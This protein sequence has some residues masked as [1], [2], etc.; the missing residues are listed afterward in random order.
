MLQ[1][2]KKAFKILSVK[3]KKMIVLLN[4][5][6]I[7]GALME[8]LGISLILP[9]ITAIIDENN[10]QKTWYAG[11]ICNLFSIQDKKIY[12][13]ILL[14]LLIAVFIVKN[15]YLLFEIYTQ[16]TFISRCRYQMQKNLM[17]C[18]MKKPYA[19]YLHANSGEIMRIMHNDTY[20][21]FN[22]LTTLIQIYTEGFVCVI[23]GAT[24][25]VLS[26]V[27]AA[28]LIV[29]LALEMLLIAL[30]VK[31][32][33]KE[34]GREFRK[35]S[36]ISYNWMLQAVNGIK[37]IKVA[38][39]ENYFCDNYAKSAGKVVNIERKNLTLGDVPRL[40]IEALT[41][42]SVLLMVLIMVINGASLESIVPQLSAFVVAAIRLLPGANRISAAINR[43]PF[44]EGG[45]DNVL[46]TLYEE[47]G[48]KNI[49]RISDMPFQA[50]FEKNDNN[51]KLRKELKV[52]NIT[53]CYPG[54]D[55][56][57]L[58]NADMSIYPGQS[59]GIIGQSG[60][61]KTTVMDIML[62]LLKPDKGE[63]IADGRNIEED[64]H[65]W[66]RNVSYIPQQIFL[67]DD[68]IIR[69][70]AFGENEEDID[71]TLVWKALEEA[72]LKDFVKSLPEGLNT[73]VGEQGIRLSGGQK[74]RIGI[75]RALYHDP[76]IIF[77][78]EA[79]SALDNDTENAIM[80]SINHL[81]G[82]KTLVIIAHRLTTIQNCDVVYKVE[83]GKIIKEGRVYQ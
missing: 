8:S 57:V 14:L 34:G 20:Q 81:K 33:L 38:N 76:D 44:Y 56:A 74:Q 18:F 28:E 16:N 66:L 47:G 63:I 51:M 27:I 54:S 82:K 36:A 3:Q 62:G 65:A 29:T 31:P 1:A 41:V 72:Q 22:L 32:I 69:N 24:I 50:S 75:A 59:A 12:I 71:Q 61:G 73:V 25:F 23:L 37:S 9:L 45:L 78:D 55:T 79:T 70:V 60:A 80:E 15:V 5:M 19:Y 52:R 77:F 58:L 10:W 40:L 68:S 42:A 7:L 67:I 2:T 4:V 53:F 49:Q 43:I 30:V 39:I 46:K 13:E 26:P 64:I 35:H 11:F 21:A 6:M 83:D 17:L 48:M